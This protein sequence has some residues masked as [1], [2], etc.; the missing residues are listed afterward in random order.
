MAQFSVPVR[1]NEQ[2]QIKATSPGY[3]TKTET[4]KESK[5]L[6]KIII[7]LKKIKE[8]CQE[9]QPEC[10]WNT[11][12]FFD[13]DS[14]VVKPSEIEKLKLISE[15]LKKY[16]K[17]KIEIQGHTDLS[18]RGPKQKSY[19]YNLRLSIERANNVKKALIELGIEESRLLI[20]GYSYTKPLVEVPDPIRGAINR[21][22]EFK[23]SQ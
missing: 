2:F 22:V 16:S 18:Y 20:K 15:I 10:I 23:E 11:R 3:E 9:M 14:A 7:K 1:K 8:P 19:E 12:I 17:I 5:D 21:R 13:L 6:E 4:F